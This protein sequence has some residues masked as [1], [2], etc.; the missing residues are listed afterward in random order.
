M[1]KKYDY[2]VNKNKVSRKDFI[3]ELK[4]CCQKVIRTD[5]IAGWCGVGLC[6]FDENKFNK[7]M[8]D[9]EKGN[10]IAFYDSNKVF[11]RKEIVE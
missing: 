11:C 2:F 4:R 5:V 8:R 10:I 7:Y 6:E 9:V 1:R 3:Y